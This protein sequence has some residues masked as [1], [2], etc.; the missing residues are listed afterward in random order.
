LV[1]GLENM[2]D[3]E[4]DLLLMVYGWSKFNWDFTSKQGEDK[5]LANYDLL[6]MRILY[7]LKSHRADRS[8]DLVSLEGPQASYNQ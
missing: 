3:K 6:N 5:Q 2:T 7:A 8:L 4:R 1:K